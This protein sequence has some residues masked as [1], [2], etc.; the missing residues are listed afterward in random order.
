MY[1]IAARKNN[2]TFVKGYKHRFIKYWL[3]II[4]YKL[5][6]YEVNYGDD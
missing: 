2:R 6:R 1:I 5:K 4:I 3:N